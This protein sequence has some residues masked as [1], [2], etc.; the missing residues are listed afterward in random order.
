MERPMRYQISE[1]DVHKQIL[2]LVLPNRVCQ[3]DLANP[4]TSYLLFDF[5]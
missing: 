1:I 2:A 5:C 4:H 3:R